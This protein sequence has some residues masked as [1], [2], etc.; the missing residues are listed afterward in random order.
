MAKFQSLKSSM[1]PLFSAKFCQIFLVFFIIFTVFTGHAFAATQ[2]P[3]VNVNMRNHGYTMGDEIHQK[4]QIYLPAN[5]SI[6]PQSLP[7]AGYINPWLDLKSVSFKQEGQTATLQLV[8]QIF[9][10]VEFTQVLKTPEIGLKNTA[11]K[12]PKIFIPPQ[13]FYYSAVLPQSVVDIQRRQN[14]SPLVFDTFSPNLVASIFATLALIGFVVWWWLQD[15]FSWLPYSA[16]PMT[17]LAR[18]LKGQLVI[19]LHHAELVY[20][21]LNQCAGKNIYLNNEAAFFEHATYLKPYD[22]EIMDFLCKANQV[23]YNHDAL[24]RGQS[25]PPQNLG[26]SAWVQ[27]AAMAERLFR[28][29]K[30]QQKHV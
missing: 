3:S 29:Q 18:K 27:K 8:W 19:S 23:I 14:L 25:Q 20:E 13:P 4:I 24:G 17:K 16:G 1:S 26:A 2:Q 9:A 7:L 22:T 10:T 6:D 28:R 12:S 21:T 30:R 5:E 11:S 15:R